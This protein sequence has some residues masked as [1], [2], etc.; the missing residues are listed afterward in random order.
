MTRNEMLLPRLSEIRRKLNPASPVALVPL[1]DAAR[2]RE[3]REKKSSVLQQRGG[4][5]TDASGETVD[6]CESS[7]SR[8][9]V[10]RG[11]EYLTPQ[12]LTR[13][14]EAL[15]LHWSV[16]EPSKFYLG[17]ASLKG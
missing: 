14:A 1:F 8:Q 12:A 9:T 4:R 16:H 10:H 7:A 17:G 6:L 13:R 15:S 11:C 5:P 3:G 2:P